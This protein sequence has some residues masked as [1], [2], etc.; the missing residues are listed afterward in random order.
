MPILEKVIKLAHDKKSLRGHLLP[1]ILKYA[2]EDKLDPEEYMKD[3]PD[4][5]KTFIK[6]IV[7]KNG[8]VDHKKLSVFLA[9][10]KGEAEIKDGEFVFKKGKTAGSTSSTPD[11][12]EGQK[13]KNP[14]TGRDV[15]FGSLPKEVQKK[16]REQ[17]SKSEKPDSGQVKGPKKSFKDRVNDNQDELAGGPGEYEKLKKS[18][19][20][21]ARSIKELA[22]TEAA[23]STFEAVFKTSKGKAALGTAAVGGLIALTLAGSSM[24]AF[25]QAA[26]N[27]KNIEWANVNAIKAEKALD[28]LNSAPKKIMNSIFEGVKDFTLG[29][30]IGDKIQKSL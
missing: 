19:P 12:A 3:A 11:W 18:D 27:R 21:R 8:K 2:E 22:E 20:K 17:H 16:L 30:D 25:N 6:S 10:A 5:I 1:I 29:K 7:D 4:S 9:L 23:T 14:A 26:K 13:F 15:Q 24:G 28:T